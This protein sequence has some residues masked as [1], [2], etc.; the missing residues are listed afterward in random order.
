MAKKTK[1]FPTFAFA[2]FIIAIL[3]ILTDTGVVGFDVPWLPLIIAVIALGSIIEF[4][5]NKK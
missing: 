3:W 1:T 4:Y 2:V 5:G